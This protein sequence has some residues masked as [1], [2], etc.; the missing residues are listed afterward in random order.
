MS[1]WSRVLDSR[2]SRRRAL[3]SFGGGAAAA[4]FIAACGGNDSGGGGS[5]VT[6]SSGDYLKPGGTW[7]ARD[8]WTVKDE[9]AKAIPGGVYP[10]SVSEE[11]PNTLDQL[12]GEYN[13]VAEHVYEWQLRR[14]AGPG[15][16]PGTAEANKIM[17]GL[18]ESWEVSPDGLRYTFRLRQ[19]VKFQNV[20]PVNGRVMD[21]EDWKSSDER[22]IAGAYQRNALVDARDKVEFTDARTMVYVLKSP[23]AELPNRISDILTHYPIVPKELNENEGALAKTQ[24][25]GTNAFI[26]DQWQ[27]GVAIRYRRNDDYWG[28]KPFIERRNYPIIPEYANRYAQFLAKNTQSFVPTPQDVMTTRNDVSDAVMYAIQPWQD[29]FRRIS[30]GK[31]GLE[32]QPYNDVRVRIALRRAINWDAIRDFLGNVDAFAKAGIEVET[33]IATHI[34]NDPSY[35]LD[36]RKGELGEVSQNYLFDVAEAKK[37]VAAAGHPNGFNIDLFVPVSPTGA[38]PWPDEHTLT[39]DALNRSGVVKITEQRFPNNAQTPYYQTNEYTGMIGPVVASGGSVDA[40][41]ARFYHATQA[42]HAFR[43]DPVMMDLIDRQRREVDPQRRIEII[44]E[45]QRYAGKVFYH[46]PCEG[47]F[48]SFGFYWPW[49]HNSVSPAALSNQREHLQWL[50]EAMPK[51][52][53]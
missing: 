19:G 15:I 33:Y 32:Q 36:P 11:I 31:V 21:M 35:W 51:R 16:Q 27:K 22:F 50:D 3:A 41:M 26:L 42:T 38:Q 4:A 23:F 34:F 10:G 48:G 40:H 8:D 25:I 45:Y 17:P 44:K 47:N 2:L 29:R 5:A 53:G 18:A 13:S 14:N 12:I 20:A 30:F 6:E 43:G 52:N 46:L 39:M 7:Y 24:A 49:L 37:L 28:G 9:T 1:Y